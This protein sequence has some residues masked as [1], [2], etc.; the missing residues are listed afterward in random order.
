[1]TR[2][3]IGEL[4]LRLTSTLPPVTLLCQHKNKK[5]I[6]LSFFLRT[7]LDSRAMPVGDNLPVVFCLR[8]S[9]CFV[10]NKKEH[11]LHELF[12]LYKVRQ[13]DLYALA[14]F[15]TDHLYYSHLKRDNIIPTTTTTD[16]HHSCNFSSSYIPSH[17][18]SLNEGK[19]VDTGGITMLQFLL[20]H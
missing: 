15:P 19:R 5:E 3:N 10:S 2:S 18:F 16:H 9:I 12:S 17:P 20:Q 11:T 6:G 14:D 13:F 1:M 4:T 8:S 7:F